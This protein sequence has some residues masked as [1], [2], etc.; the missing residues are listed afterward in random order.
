MMVPAIMIMVLNFQEPHGICLVCSTPGNWDRCNRPVTQGVEEKAKRHR[1]LWTDQ[2]ACTIRVDRA[3]CGTSTSLVQH[4]YTQW[5][6]AF[7]GH[8]AADIWTAG[9]Y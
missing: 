2:L 5:K 6:L 3:Q 9:I 4:V 7:A 1:H 8:A